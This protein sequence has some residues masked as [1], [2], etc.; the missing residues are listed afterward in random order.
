MFE[1]ILWA[2]IL[3]TLT[4]ATHGLYSAYLLICLRGKY[5]HTGR[6]HLKSHL[7][8]A[9]VVACL[10]LVHMLE[11]ALWAFFFVWQKGLPDFASALYFSLTSYATIGYGDILLK[12]NLRLVGAAEG[13]VGSLMVGWS[14][15]LLVALLQWM[16][17]N[18]PP[19]AV[20][21]AP[22]DDHADGKP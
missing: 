17:K 5:A 6:H 21:H 13:L 9:R 3:T 14:V 22:P 12:D 10:L 16:V 7:L 18:S 19:P 2:V 15:A 1:Q 8:V 11:A 20:H 4:A